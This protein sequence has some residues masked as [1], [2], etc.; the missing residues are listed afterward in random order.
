MLQT[1]VQLFRKTLFFFLFIV[2]LTSAQLTPPSRFSG[3]VY[4]D[5]E[6]ADNVKICGEVKNYTSCTYSEN[7]KYVLDVLNGSNGDKIIFYVEDANV[8]SA[9]YDN[10][11]IQ[12][13]NL[14]AFKIHIKSWLDKNKY[15]QGEYVKISAN[16]ST[17]NGNINVSRIWY[18]VP[19][20][21][22]KGNLTF[23]NNL[24]VSDFST[25]SLEGSYNLKVLTKN[26]P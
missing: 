23:K 17:V 24:Y 16:T 15:E 1:V 8:S 5:N 3:F 21:N 2:S 11:K 7:G 14:S 12:T 9:T 26:A 10:T 22:I 4:V 6:P 20:T 18:E 25:S 13:K 19:G